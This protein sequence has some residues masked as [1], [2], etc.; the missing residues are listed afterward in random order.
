M[1]NIELNIN[2]PA[3]VMEGC[4]YTKEK[5]QELYGVVAGGAGSMK[6]EA[7]QREMVISGTSLP[8]PKTNMRINTRTNQM[9]EISQPMIQ[10]DGFDWTENFDG[11]QEI[12]SK[13]VWV[14]FKSVV[15]TGGS[16]TRTLRDECYPF[17]KAQLN[18]LVKSNTTDNYFANIFD[19]DEAAAKMRQFKYLLNLP[20]FSTVKKYVYV[21]D[22]KSYFPWLKQICAE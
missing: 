21:G 16:Q 18:W 8:C 5:R 2:C 11:K 10:E 9:K 3:G 1:A 12:S 20:E 7:F 13:K 14:N 22:L 4:Q 17:T 19:G 15:G 6:P